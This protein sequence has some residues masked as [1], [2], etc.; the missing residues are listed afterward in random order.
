M[1]VPFSYKNHN[2]SFLVTTNRLKRTP[3]SYV[4]K[5]PAIASQMILLKTFSFRVLVCLL[6]A[7]CTTGRRNVSAQQTSDVLDRISEIIRTEDARALTEWASN[8]VEIAVFGPSKTYS[9]AQATFVL[10]KFFDSVDILSFSVE[11]YTRS[12]RG[13]FVEGSIEAHDS[14]YPLRVYLRMQQS[15]DGWILREVIFER[16]SD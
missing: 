13:L 10:E 2:G 5:N 9:V 7:A 11:E 1:Q 12:E 8:P 14:Q 3:L 6:L 16:K 4:I 15:V